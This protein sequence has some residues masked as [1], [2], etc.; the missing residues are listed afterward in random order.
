MESLHSF[1]L[2]SKTDNKRYSISLE[3]DGM[4]VTETASGDTVKFPRGDRPAAFKMTRLPFLPVMLTVTWGK[5]L[6][7]R[8]DEEQVETISRWNGPL[9]L[10]DLALLQKERYKLLLPIAVV[11]IILSLPALKNTEGLIHNRI[12]GYMNLG[13]GTYLLFIYILSKTSLSR[14]VFLLD[15]LWFI[16]AGIVVALDVFFAGRHLSLILVPLLLIG[17]WSGMYEFRRFRGVN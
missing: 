2:V 12:S 16:I 7:F 4:V 11:L 13:L 8:L 15:S 9:T 1:E 14:T 3:N 10:L 5:K 6:V 17:A